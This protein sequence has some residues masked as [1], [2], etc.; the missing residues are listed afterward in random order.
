MTLDEF[1]RRLTNLNVWKQGKQRAPHKPLLLLLAM[2][3]AARGEERLAP[4]NEIEETLTGLL[5]HFGPPRQAHHPEFPFGRLVTDGLWEIPDADSLRRTGSGDL[6]KTELQTRGVTGGLPEPLYQL[7]VSDPASAQAAAEW[8]VDAHFPV[9]MRQHILETVGLEGAVREESNANAR[10]RRDPHFR[11]LVLTAYERRCAICGFDLR[12]KDDL[13]GL[14]AAHIQWHSH[15]GPDSVANGL[16]LCTFHHGAFDRG[17]V[18]LAKTAGDGGYRSLVS[19][20]INGESPAISW[21]LDYHGAP[22][23]P[24]QNSAGWPDER[25]V[26][27]H[28]N[29]VFRAPAR[30]LP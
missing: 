20:D 18:G 25:Y 5:R 24:P 27:W 2:G 10:P 21:L 6:Y 1:R 3:R 7:L 19:Q 30:H 16:A 22:V 17:A 14:E 9:S 29:E 12:L 28:S 13:L 15:G 11:E 8:I 26:E 23:R 4:F